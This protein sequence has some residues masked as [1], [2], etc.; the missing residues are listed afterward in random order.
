M[1]PAYDIFKKTSGA[2]LFVW[3]E[4]A[5]DIVTAKKRLF[6]LVSVAPA[7]YKLWDAAQERFVDP[8]ED[9]A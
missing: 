2:N 5:E 6:T 7:E 9:C 3:I 1:T 8:P 4:A